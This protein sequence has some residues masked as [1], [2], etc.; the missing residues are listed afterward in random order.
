M[1]MRTLSGGGN[2]LSVGAA[3]ALQVPG[4]PLAP[5]RSDR[6]FSSR[7]PR[8]AGDTVFGGTSGTGNIVL[9][10]NTLAEAQ[11]WQ[12]NRMCW[13]Y[14]GGDVA[15]V[16][17]WIA[18]GYQVQATINTGPSSIS[19]VLPSDWAGNAYSADSNPL[20]PAPF[21][22]AVSNRQRFSPHVPFAT[23]CDPAEAARKRTE[24]E[25]FISQGA[26]SIQVDDPRD[27][28]FFIRETVTH[29]EMEIGFRAWLL[30]N[31]TLAERS[32]QGLPDPL[33]AGL[34][35]WMTTD[36]TSPFYSYFH[37]GLTNPLEIDAYRARVNFYRINNNDLASDWRAWQVWNNWYGKYI[38][39]TVLAVYA[40][41]K[42]LGVPVSGNNFRF[43][44]SQT[45]NWSAGSFDWNLYEVSVQPE[46]PGSLDSRLTEV[47]RIWMGAI[48][49]DARGTRGCGTLLPAPPN[50]APAGF[51][52]DVLKQH[53]ATLYATGINALAPWDI[54]MT[55]AQGV[56]ASNYRFMANPS[57]YTD[58]YSFVAQIANLLDGFEAVPDIGLSASMDQFPN[59]SITN[60]QPS[61]LRQIARLRQLLDVGLTPKVYLFGSDWL[62]ETPALT[63]PYTASWSNAVEYGRNAR[64]M[65]GME[66]WNQVNP[67]AL[68]AKF[69]RVS[70]TG[71]SAVR[72]WLR[73]NGSRQ[74]IHLTNYA[75]SADVQQSQ[76]AA[77]TLRNVP[78]SGQMR[79]HRPGHAS[80]V[81]GVGSA[82]SVDF[83]TVLE[84]L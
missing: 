21:D 34:V 57:D 69:G 41:L 33:P 72:A 39:E 12:T 58:L 84:L 11:A 43:D 37:T 14:F 54:Y 1:A 24:V 28:M 26:T 75:M 55:A 27:M 36:V 38:R 52:R 6:M 17:S 8:F 77:V 29:P 45:R 76:Q 19:T 65:R 64:L 7:V 70:V 61:Y 15:S 31:T 9:S 80:Y 46:Y 16:S 4:S 44:P 79:V 73:S 49:C 2:P 20:R 71:S 50:A 48:C 47:T 30:A 40:E 63:M 25:T 67:G 10:R 62:Q 82:V 35:A 23:L 78:H 66:N 22:I 13:T 3:F 5:L 53:I 42:T 74:V 18:A 81:T 59:F 68:A 56:S 60:E 51:V 32:S 83:W